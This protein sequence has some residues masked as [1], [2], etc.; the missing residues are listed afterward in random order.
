MDP[1]QPMITKEIREKIY[2]ETNENKSTVIQNLRD[3]A[4]AVLRGKFTAT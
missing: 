2:L 1:K 3:P 4:K